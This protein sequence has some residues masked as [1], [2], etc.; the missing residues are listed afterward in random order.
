MAQ[1]YR[2]Y[3]GHTHDTKVLDVEDSLRKAVV[4]FGI[5]PESE[6]NIRTKNVRHLSER[7]LAARLKA[8]RAR[9]AALNELGLKTDV[10]AQV[11]R[12]QQQEQQILDL[13]VEGILREFHFED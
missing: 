8:L 4:A 7:L 1:W 5:A 10:E 13:G 11:T 3:T 6:R 12:L 9:R 2:G